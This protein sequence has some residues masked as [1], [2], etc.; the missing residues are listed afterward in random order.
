MR[1]ACQEPLIYRKEPYLRISSR[2]RFT[3]IELLITIAIIAILAGV[4]LP[5]LNAA[6]EKGRAA[7]CIGNIRQI[8]T[9]AVSYAG[10]FNDHLPPQNNVIIDN[11]SHLTI[12]NKLYLYMDGKEFSTS[13]KGAWFCPS[14]PVAPPQEGRMFY[15]SYSPIC[16]YGGL[17][18]HWCGGSNSS[19]EHNTYAYTARLSKLRPDFY[20]LTNRQ[21]APGALLKNGQPEASGAYGEMR[22]YCL[23]ATTMENLMNPFD[24]DKGAVGQVFVH[25]NR[26]PFLLANGGV[27][28]RI[29]GKLLQPTRSANQGWLADFK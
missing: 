10:D 20:L 21:C 27:I 16:T 4:L 25:Q 6:R 11:V 22:V 29:I 17:N 8:N 23:K 13:Q 3:L 19:T 12:R 15:A 1:E 14:Y 5:A 26:A 24:K 9:A 7:V 18:S 28:T 2:R